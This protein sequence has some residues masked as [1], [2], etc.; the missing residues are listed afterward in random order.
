MQARQLDCL[1]NKSTMQTQTILCL[2]GLR[3]IFTC[4]IYFMTV[5]DQVLQAEQASA[6]ALQDAKNTAQQAVSAAETAKA[7]AINEAKAT[8]EEKRVAAHTNATAQ[9]EREAADLVSAAQT[10]AAAVKSQ[11]ENQAA[12]LTADLVAAYKAA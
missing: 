11:V 4:F 3:L 10:E 1:G 2:S 6:D 12:T 8:A 9:V 5:L 7:T